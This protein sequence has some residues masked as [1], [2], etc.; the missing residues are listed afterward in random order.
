MPITGMFLCGFQPRQSLLATEDYHLIDI[1]QQLTT[2]TTD[3]P[4]LPK[5]VKHPS[6]HCQRAQ[7]RTFL[8]SVLR[9]AKMCF[10]F[11]ISD[12]R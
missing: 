7:R 10:E 8:F 3:D 5:Q 2:T 4:G 1:D 11:R 9:F 12:T 6:L